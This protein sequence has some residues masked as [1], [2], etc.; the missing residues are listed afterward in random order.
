MRSHPPLGNDDMGDLQMYDQHHRSCVDHLFVQAA[1]FRNINRLAIG[2]L[3]GETHMRSA[4]HILS[5]YEDALRDLATQIFS[6]VNP[7]EE[8]RQVNP[9]KRRCV[10]RVESQLNGRIW[11][12]FLLSSHDSG[13]WGRSALRCTEATARSISQT[14]GLV[15]FGDSSHWCSPYG[16]KSGC[17][18]TTNVCTGRG[19]AVLP[20]CD[21]TS[22]RGSAWQH[23]RAFVQKER[24]FGSSLRY[25][26]H[27]RDVFR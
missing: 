22:T 3:S 15:D 11:L 21:C 2:G 27:V 7:K 18:N 26:N 5:D 8:E 16:L 23:A 25:H 13:T 12:C 6:T 19:N 4:H 20:L 17:S 14:K 9:S 24:V 10:S 1:L